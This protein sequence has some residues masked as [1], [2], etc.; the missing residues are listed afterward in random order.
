[1]PHVGR[2][3][4]TRRSRVIR[5]ARNRTA[6]TEDER[7]AHRARDLA[8]L[9][10]VGVDCGIGEAGEVLAAVVVEPAGR[11]ERVDDRLEGGV[12]D[13]VEQIDGRRAD[14]G[15]ERTERLLTFI[16]APAVTREDAQ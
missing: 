5:D 11:A 9:V 12:R 10:D 13:A 7:L 6:R 4:M 1:M 2:S 3:T 15:L 14:L 8:A 16:G